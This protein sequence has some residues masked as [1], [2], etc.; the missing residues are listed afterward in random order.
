MEDHI[1]I[2]GLDSFVRLQEF[3]ARREEGEADGF[4]RFEIELCEHV[5]ALENEL[6]AAELARYDVDADAIW[7][8]GR[9]WRRCL[10][11]QPKTYMSSSGPVAVPRN[12]FRPS[13]G[14]KAIC[15]LELRAGI[16]GGLHT[17]VLARQICYLMGH[18][19]SVETAGVFNEFEIQ[20]RRAA[21][22]TVFPRSSA[23]TGS[24]SGRSGKTP[25]AP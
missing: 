3:T 2:T 8:N 11:G 4:E 21:H 13:E 1:S 9:E 22:A 15:P 19:T 16:L 24:R 18:L 10:T 25:C 23:L 14:G 20:V 6:K 17:P 7:V 5:R 12:L